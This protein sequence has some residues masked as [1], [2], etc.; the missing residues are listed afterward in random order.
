MSLEKDEDDLFDKKGEE[1]KALLNKLKE[2]S[3][4][5]SMTFEI[6][7][8]RGLTRVRS[9]SNLAAVLIESKPGTDIK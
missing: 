6:E 9:G 4:N 2:E 3:K 7:K 5:G 1:S 8:K